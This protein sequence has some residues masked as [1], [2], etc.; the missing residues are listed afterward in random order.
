MDSNELDPRESH[1]RLAANRSTNM[2]NDL[3]TWLGRSMALVAGAT[4]LVGCANDGPTNSVGP[5]LTPG[6]PSFSRAPEL[7]ACDR[8]N[9]P[10]GARLVYHAYARGVQIYRWSGSAWTLNGPDAIL[11][12]DAGGKS[13][14]GTHYVGP[15]WESNS[16]SKVVGAVVDRCTPNPN[17]VAWL[18]LSGKASGKGIFGSVTHIQRVNTVGGVAPSTPGAFVGDEVRIDYST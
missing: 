3:R 12:A 6:A 4:M 14:V 2:R 17:A 8:L 5:S 13:V 11:S 1:T 9:A 7:G 15:T 16:G 10:A 18:L